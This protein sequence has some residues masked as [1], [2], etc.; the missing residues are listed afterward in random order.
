[1]RLF[2]NLINNQDLHSQTEHDET[3]GAE[4]LNESDSEEEETNKTSAL[5]NFIPQILPDDEIVE[6]I[7]SLNSKQKEVFN[8]VHT[9]TKDYV[10]CDGH[11]VEQ[12][13]LFFSGSGGTGKSHLVKVICNAILKTLLYNCKDPEKLKSFFTWVYSNISS[14]YSYSV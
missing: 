10:K 14:K 9:W 8:V 6:G 4:Y 7:N 13:H 2:C 11:S 12:N 3:P 5:P 1:M